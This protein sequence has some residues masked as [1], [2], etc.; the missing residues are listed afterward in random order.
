MRLMRVLK[1]I[2]F[3]SLLLAG[4]LAVVLAAASEARAAVAFGSA[5]AVD[6]GTTTLVVPYPGGIAAGNLLVLTVGNKYPPNGPATLAG[7]TLV[8]NGQI[9]GGAGAP[10]GDSG[11]V[12]ATIF[13][14]VADGS[15]TG[16][17]TV[18]LTGANSSMGRMFR[19]TNAAGAGWDY[20]AT[21]G[22]DNTP[23]ATWSVTG[24]ANPG[25]TAGDML[26]VVSAI[27]GNRMSGWASE[28]VSAAG[29]TFGIH[30]ERQD[31]STAAGQ[32]MA[33]V[34]SDHTVTA[35]TASAA[36][37]F[38]MTGTGTPTANTPA[39][40]SV[41]LRIREVPGT[42]LGNGTD[43]ANS[44]IGPGGP[45]TMADA[46][47][48]KT[49]A[50]TDVITSVVVGLSAGS[51]GGL[52]LVEITDDAGTTV[53]GS[54]A[55][56]ASDTPSITLSTNTLTATTT[57][58]Q[59]KIRI[60]PKSHAAMPAPPGATYPVTA[61]INS[62]TGTNT[63]GGS[64]SAGTTVTIDNQSPGDV[65]GASGAAG[66]TQVT[67]NWTNPGDADLNSIVVLRDTVAVADSPVEGTTYTVGNTI[68]TNVVRCVV[69]PPTAGCTDTG[70]TNGTAYH[71]KIFTRDTNGNY[72]VGVVPTGSPF[73][74][75]GPG[76]YAV[77]SAAWNMASTWASTSGGTPGTCPGTGNIPDASTPVFIG[78][79]STAY[80]VTIPAGY[81]AQAANV[82]LGSSTNNSKS[83]TLS[84]ATASLAVGGNLIIYNPTNNNNTNALNVDAGTVTVGS[85]V[86]LNGT[87]TANS[88]V[89]RINITTGTLTINGGLTYNAGGPPRAVID[90]SGG[91]GT[92]NLAGALT[93][94][95]AG[96]LTP[97]ASSTFN[98]N[99]TA[100]QT[101][102]LNVATIDYYNL[103]I[104]NTSSSGATL[105]A[106][107]DTNNVFGNL[108]IGNITPGVILNS[109]T[110]NITG[111]GTTLEVTN[112]SRLNY[113]GANAIAGFNAVTLGATS[114]VDYMRAGDQTV[115]NPPPTSVYGHLY[116]SGSGTKTLPN[117]AMTVAGDL[118]TTSTATLTADTQANLTINGQLNIGSGTTFDAGGAFT[119]TVGGNFTNNGAFTRRTSTVALNGAANQTLE[120]AVATT[121]NNLTIANSGGAVVTAN[122]GFTTVGS[123]AINSGASFNAG[124]VTHNIQGPT[125]SFTN[126]GTFTAGTST[127]VFNGSAAQTLTSAAI[128]LYN[129]TMNNTSTGLTINDDVT[130]TNTLAFASGVINTPDPLVNPKGVIIAP[131]AIVTRGIGN[132]GHVAGNLIK[133][134]STAATPV[135]YEVGDAGTATAAR[136]TPFTVTFDTVDAP[137][138]LR[139]YTVIG[140]HPGTTTGNNDIDPALSVNRYWSLQQAG[141]GPSGLT[142]FSATVNYID[143]DDVDG[144]MP[145]I[146]MQ[147]YDGTAWDSFSVTNA[148]SSGGVGTVSGSGATA[149]SGAKVGDIAVGNDKNPAFGREVQFIYTSERP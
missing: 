23:D 73:T 60:T 16:N 122:T 112:L 18:T 54:V 12:Y 119:H 6:P 81:A 36:P 114:I 51:S 67:L 30:T 71:Y 13:V 45:A 135:T 65:T 91:A 52:S 15:E 97:G 76:C 85:G 26:V 33:L 25:V 102:L 68:G 121:F 40:A 11:T 29:A 129:L 123:F 118:I 24:A 101:V 49:S 64:D 20:A 22:S 86:T 32:D 75:F 128:S 78:E 77:A 41:I 133:N 143:P 42:T 70:L 141:A 120:G 31:S 79:T 136:Y 147:R 140:D 17:L 34:V 50:G 117:T 4:T 144:A 89:A 80:N 83:L 125:P 130:V 38:T 103:H 94:T 87:S 9:S 142:T 47:T 105:N 53:Y 55:N 95:T 5:G 109:N 116:L 62:W 8:T 7:W 44:A 127:I 149:G 126:S 10:G 115:I 37:V 110:F 43:P 3:P 57:L 66:N 27:N 88:R 107:I 108:R 96:R 58:T 35:G 137:G 56:P 74:P 92:L 146:I 99:G 104:N 39:G 139:G 134:I 98:Y 14:K 59:Y 124:A 131:G 63:Q 28:S 113:G 82:T 72:A 61:K 2:R 48:F 132:A 145:D 1:R 21:N 148:S 69:T 100:A 19:Y 106:N 90:M 111:A 84:A 46:F 93:V 138:N